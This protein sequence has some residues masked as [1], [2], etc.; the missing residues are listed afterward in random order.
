MPPMAPEDIVL[1]TEDRAPDTDAGLV[2]VP[3]E[4]TPNVE[5]VVTDVVTGV[6]A[7]AVREA[8]V[9]ELIEAMGLA[10]DVMGKVFGVVRETALD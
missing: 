3:P 4:L 8:V 10:D 2:A 6:S 1:V 7:E 9:G 5:D